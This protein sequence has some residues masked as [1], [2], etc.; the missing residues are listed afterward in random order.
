MMARWRVA[1]IAIAIVVPIGAPLLLYF[2]ATRGATLGW[3]SAV[4]IVG[5]LDG[6]GID[7]VIGI[8]RYVQADEMKLTAVSGKDGHTLWQT[9]SLGD[10]DA[11][12]R[13]KLALANGVV[14][15]ADT[16]KR[17]HVEAF[18]AKTGAKKWEQTPS[19]VV[20][21][22]CRTASGVVIVTKDKRGWTFEPTT[23]ALS[24]AV[25][26]EPCD[27]LS[28]DLRFRS[29]D[30]PHRDVTIDGMHHS[31][32]LGDKPPFIA[33]GVKDPGS[34]IPMV[35]ALDGDGHLLWKAEVP[36]TNPLGARLGDPQLVAYD[37][38]DIAVAYERDS[39]REPPRVV[40]FERAT[41][42]RRFEVPAKHEGDASTW[43]HGIALGK[44]AVFVAVDNSLQAFDRTTGKL[45][46]FV[47]DLR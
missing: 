36:G 8:G 2:S 37:D 20:D 9:P 1:L 17:A 18:D 25:A 45:L 35:A 6:D 46:W 16:D 15:R 32:I 26:P 19:E 22:L 44:Q 10:Y 14:L 11:I 21:K 31:H 38:T 41:G 4:P 34:S 12:Y 40:S 3:D 43:L 13:S 23:G 28:G 33:T 7:D 42:K 5:D 29:V 30:E 24:P 47:G 27:E 39:S